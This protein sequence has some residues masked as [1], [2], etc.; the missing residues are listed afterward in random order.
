[1]KRLANSYLARLVMENI[2]LEEAAI[3]CLVLCENIA[4]N[5]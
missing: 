2:L 5:F 3:M 4:L 1:M